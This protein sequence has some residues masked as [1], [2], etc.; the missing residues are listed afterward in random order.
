M[1]GHGCW[2]K[3]DYINCSPQKSISSFV[4]P[5]WAICVNHPPSRSNI[6][7]WHPTPSMSIHWSPSLSIGWTGM[8][9]YWPWLT[10]LVHR[11]VISPLLVMHGG[12][13]NSESECTLT[14]ASCDICLLISYDS[15]CL[16]I[17]IQ[18]YARASCS[19]LLPSPHT[20]ASYMTAV[21]E[22]LLHFCYL[23]E[24]V[25]RRV[26]MCKRKDV[27]RHERSGNQCSLIVPYCAPLLG[28]TGQW[29]TNVAGVPAAAAAWGA[30]PSKHHRA[31]QNS[32][33]PHDE[34]PGH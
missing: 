7:Q 28:Y 22:A 25:I 23:E 34:A 20:T 12:S 9:P 21:I 4:I 10:S 16:A 27:Y 1:E 6:I 29:S 19:I 13:F 5:R 26:H 15:P 14:D 3:G 31:S 32:A 33:T 30:A 2:W 18:A 17:T 11:G 8:D 24:A